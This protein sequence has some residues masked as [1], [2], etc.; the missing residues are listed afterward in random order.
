L[1]YQRGLFEAMY[2]YISLVFG[3]AL[4][5]A[6]ILSIRKL[7]ISLRT[8]P[9][10]FYVLAHVGVILF[11]LILGF[12]FCFAEYKVPFAEAAKYK[13]YSFPILAGGTSGN[14]DYWGLF[15]IP[16]F[17]L[18]FVIGFLFPALSLRYILLFLERKH[19]VKCG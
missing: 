8:L 4:L 11:G 6:E 9:I 15:S 14:I 13:F 17:I 10:G 2:F 7:R 5:I 18:N 12:L 16:A 1:K 19:K 3:A